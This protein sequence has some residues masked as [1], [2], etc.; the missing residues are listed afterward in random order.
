MLGLK[1]RRQHRIRGLIVDFYCPELG[2]VLEID[3]AIHDDVD[4][5]MYDQ[6]RTEYLEKLGLTVLRVPNQRVTNQY[7]CDLI[8][9]LIKPNK[10]PG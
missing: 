3:G 6:S 8:L 10:D 4:Q 9:P 1:F 5:R 2:L 7:L